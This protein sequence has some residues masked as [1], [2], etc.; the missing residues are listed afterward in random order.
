LQHFAQA[1]LLAGDGGQ[2]EVGGGFCRYHVF[3]CQVARDVSR[4]YARLESRGT[5]WCSARCI[6]RLRAT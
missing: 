3:G 1:D 5:G 6:S 2:G 4:V